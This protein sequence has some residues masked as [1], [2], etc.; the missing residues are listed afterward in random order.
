MSL[1]LV[2][3]SH[4]TAPIELREQVDFS[5]RDVARAVRELAGRRATDECVILSTCNRVEIYAVAEPGT[6]RPAIGRF[7]AEY[8]GLATDRL[9]PHLYLQ[10]DAAATRHLFRV[11]GGLDSLVVGEPQIL[12]QVKQAY[13]VAVDAHAT[14]PLLN[15][16]FHC[17]LSAGKRVR[18]ET[19]IGEGAVSV[20]YAALSLARKIFG[21]LNGLTALIV[22]A[23]EMA[24]ITA[25]HLRSQHVGEIVVGSRRLAS[26]TALANR[27][28]GSAIPWS[29]IGRVLERADVVVT[30]TGASDPVLTLDRVQAVMRTRRNRPLFIIDLGV[31]RD[32]E[33]SAGEL[34]QVFLYNIDDLQGIVSESM[35][36]RGHQVERADAIVADE[37]DKF[38]GW[39]RS[40]NAV[41]TVVALRQRFEEIR[42]AEL[43]R[44]EPKLGALSPE[45]RARVD[46]VTRLIVEKLLLTPTEQLKSAPD[47]RTIETWADA[48]AR[49]FGFSGDVEREDRPQID[50]DKRS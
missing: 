11:A 20:S 33:P 28:D 17:A 19:G 5:T 50:A 37:V 36:R 49:L 31:P 2:G 39:W 24:K 4:R 47:Q 42:R 23:G 22:G 7:V 34:E 40:R 16:L 48:L 45:A 38:I 29:E 21:E 27:V 13:Q 1:I 6:A 41:P 44:L 12:G 35:S 32:V 8:H 25:T 3:L 18:A 46:D 10:L 26:A 15:R 14:G 9:D 30:A 43:Q